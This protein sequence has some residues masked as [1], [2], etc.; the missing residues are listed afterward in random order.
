MLNRRVL[1]ISA[2]GA[3]F[4]A[5][6]ETPAAGP[7]LAKAA[8]A[9]VGVTRDYDPAYVKLDYPGGDV[10][11]RTGVCADVVI[12]AGRDGLGLDLQRLVNR[13]MKAAFEAYPSRRAWGL[14]KPD[15]NIDHRRV[16]NL[17]VYF[18]RQG[19][20]LWRTG[21]GRRGGHDFPGGVEP[22]DIVS[23]VL[24]NG[25]P[26]IGVVTAG[27]RLPRIVHNIGGGAEEQPL[28]LMWPHKAVGHFRWP[29]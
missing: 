13:D 19:A 7:K 1:M 29:A 16:L 21:A 23:W 8:R 22:G 18:R 17:E 11:R 3:A 5:L 12:R 15:P 2:L 26:H 14:T 24:L 28:A 25:R 9:Q 20:Q 6:A 4:P 10:P 27:G